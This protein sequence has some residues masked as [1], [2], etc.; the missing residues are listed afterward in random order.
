MVV[1]LGLA[2]SPLLASSGSCASAEVGEPFL[3]PDGSEHPA[4][5]LTLCLGSEFTPVTSLYRTFVDR[6]PVGSFASRRVETDRSEGRFMM[7]DR[8]AEGTL[9]LAGY[10]APSGDGAETFLLRRPAQV[11]VR[12]NVRSALDESISTD[13]AFIRLAAALE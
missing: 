10:T 4:G 7:F 12:H 8:N 11:R 2:S 13:R 5:R 6:M 9:R 3:L 1:L